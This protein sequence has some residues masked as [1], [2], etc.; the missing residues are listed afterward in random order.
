MLAL[1]LMFSGI[2][3]LCKNYPGMISLGL[4]ESVWFSSNVSKISF[5]GV[6][7]INDICFMVFTDFWWII[8]VFITIVQFYLALTVQHCKSFPYI[9]IRSSGSQNFFLSDLLMLRE[10]ND[11]DLLISTY[12]WYH[13]FNSG[14]IVITKLV[15]FCAL[16]ALFM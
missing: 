13:S 5:L 8:K 16:P 4:K 6:A 2:Y 1:C 15:N 12:I 9:H 10:R 7:T 14:Q 11:L 3:P